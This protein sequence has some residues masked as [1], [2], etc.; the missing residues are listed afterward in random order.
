MRFC[1]LTLIIS[2]AAG[3]KGQSD[4]SD[5]TLS[6][7]MFY[8]TYS[9][10]F[11]GGDLD[12]RFGNN[13]S[14]GGGFSWKTNQNWITGAEFNFL[15]GN[16]VKIADQIMNN[17]KTEDGAIINMAGN[18]TS[19][20]VYER[21][22]YI[23]ARIGKLI[24]VLSPNPNSGITIIGSLGYLQHK[25]RIEVVENT[26]PQLKDDYKKGYDRLAGGFGASEFIGYTYLSNSR[27]L[28]FYLGFEI[29]QAWTKARRDV[30]FDTGKP[31]EIPKRFDVL[32]GIKV[33]WIV[34]LFKRMPEKYYY[35]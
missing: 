1:I 8:A 27:L 34:P 12:D 10:Q 5:T 32:Y 13:S 4:I 14:I 31:D 28:N 11:P 3:L 6:I 22:Y 7:P 17:L 15:F 35:Y 16:D 20:S 19:Y 21:G 26:A 18:Y 2:L 24:P 23:S 33:G 25:I 9:Y 29:N 30:D